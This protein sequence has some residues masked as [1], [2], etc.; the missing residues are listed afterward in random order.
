MLK[1][2]R[3]AARKKEQERQ[4]GKIGKKEEKKSNMKVRPYFRF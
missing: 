2:M 1:Q 4:K 3:K